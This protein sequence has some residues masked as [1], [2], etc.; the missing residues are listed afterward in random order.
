MNKSKLWP[1]FAS[2]TFST[3]VSGLFTC[4]ILM[5]TL[6]PIQRQLALRTPIAVVDFGEAVLSLGPNASEQDIESR[7][8]QTNQQIEKL[9][10]AGFIVLDAQ[11]VVGADD[12]VFVPVNSMEVSHADTP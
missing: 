12:S 2:I 1:L 6:D 10:A 8:F 5:K 7:L 11:A 4:W 3:A 9:K